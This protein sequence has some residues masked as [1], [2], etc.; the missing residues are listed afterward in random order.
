MGAYLFYGLR[1]IK[2]AKELNAF[3]DSDLANQQLRK[4]KRGV[5][6]FDESDV[7]WE[8]DNNNDYASEY[9]KKRIGTGDF[10][11]SGIGED[12]LKPIGLNFDTLLETLTRIFERCNRVFTMKYLK[13][14]CA[15]SG[16]YFT[17]KQINII[18]DNGKLLS[19]GD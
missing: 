14:S 9:C 12:E 3:L 4:I 5:Y 7:Q 19:G 8:K 10:K 6:V 17:Q 18:T 2:Q 16:D 13:R 1:D 15:F 11:A